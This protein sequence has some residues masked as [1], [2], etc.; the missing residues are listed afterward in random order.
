MKKENTV[1][2]PEILAIK[3]TGHVYKI[4]RLFKAHTN[5]NVHVCQGQY[6]NNMERHP[7]PGV[8]SF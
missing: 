7:G 5:V 4:S 3:L 1:F 6:C 8:E 2:S